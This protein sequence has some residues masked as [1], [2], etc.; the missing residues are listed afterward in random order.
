MRDF[1][2]IEKSAFHHGQYIGYA[3]GVWKIR[4]ACGEW[5][6]EQREH[7]HATLFGK[8]LAELSAR[9]SKIAA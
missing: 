4:R 8:T 2:N 7:K 6:A 3:D 9:L 1:P 5:C